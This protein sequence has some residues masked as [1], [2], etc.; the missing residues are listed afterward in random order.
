MMPQPGERDDLPPE[1]RDLERA[2]QGVRFEPRPSLAPEVIGRV[3]RGEAPALPEWRPAWRRWPFVAGGGALVLAAAALLLV[4]GAPSRTIDRCCFDLDGE[5]KADDGVVIERE[6]DGVRS[7]L[8][9][10]DR[11]G[12]RRYHA[13]SP[14]RF[15]RDAS[16]AVSA[17]EGAELVTV[18]LCCAD[19]DG[20]GP[21]DDG[22]LVAH[23]DGRI[24]MAA[25]YDTRDGTMR[26]LR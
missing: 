16:P 26:R 9:Y 19:Y 10:E 2:L 14:V 22:L 20:D 18:D 12:A 5:G 24:R 4:L 25:L 11:R 13:E 23:A 17:P 8:I 6:R 21:D 1:L 15:R 7:L 3:R